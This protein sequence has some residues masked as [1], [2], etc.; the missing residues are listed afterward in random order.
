V[1][2]LGPFFAILNASHR[3]VGLDEDYD[4]YLRQL[5]EARQANPPRH[6]GRR[7]VVARR[8]GEHVRM[9]LP[10]RARRMF[11]QA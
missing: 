2:P 4:E 8:L 7:Q 10:R 1:K 11:R 6:E 5:T 9:H 3:P